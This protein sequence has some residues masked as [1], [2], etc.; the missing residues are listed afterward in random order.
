M[1]Y[2]WRSEDDLKESIPSFSHADPRDRTLV[3]SFGHKLIY[4]LSQITSPFF[5]LVISY[6]WDHTI[7][8]SFTQSIFKVHPFC[9]TPG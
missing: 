4:L 3:V 5:G 7:C 8:G 1:G 9:S 6:E 2:T